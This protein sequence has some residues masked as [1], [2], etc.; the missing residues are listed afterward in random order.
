MQI[1]IDIPPYIIWESDA[2]CW[3]ASDREPVSDFLNTTREAGIAIYNSSHKK[4]VQGLLL[5]P[6]IVRIRVKMSAKAKTCD[7]SN[8]T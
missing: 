7:M 6:V 1:G 5:R 8:V 4:P 2:R 3:D